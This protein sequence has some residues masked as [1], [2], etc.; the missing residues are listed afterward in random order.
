MN[1]V[2]IGP[3]RSITIEDVFCDEHGV[4]NADLPASRG[5]MLFTKTRE[6]TRV[7]VKMTYA[8]EADLQKLVEMGFEAGITQCLEQLERRL[9]Q[10][11]V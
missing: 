3:H 8:S 2:G 7:E 11:G 1:Y 10:R 9:A 5:P 4:V 6:G